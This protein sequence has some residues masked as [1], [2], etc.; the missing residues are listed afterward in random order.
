MAGLPVLAYQQLWMDKGTS[1]KTEYH[2]LVGTH[3]D[4]AASTQQLLKVLCSNEDLA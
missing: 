2:S 1:L 3:L 4:A